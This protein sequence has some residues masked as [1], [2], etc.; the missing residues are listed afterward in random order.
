MLIPKV[1]IYHRLSKTDDERP[2]N[3]DEFFNS[4]GNVT[5]IGDFYSERITEFEAIR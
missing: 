5:K 4:L 3:Y 1:Y 2:N